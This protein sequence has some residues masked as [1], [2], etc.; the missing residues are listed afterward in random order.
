MLI[1]IEYF[2]GRIR[3]N[4][5]KK[6]FKILHIEI[7]PAFT[8]LVMQGLCRLFTEMTQSHTTVLAKY[9]NVVKDSVLCILG[10]TEIAK[11]LKLR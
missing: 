8:E 5:N 3:I 7:F 4:Q 2:L 1:T 10:V 11:L 9:L 6:S